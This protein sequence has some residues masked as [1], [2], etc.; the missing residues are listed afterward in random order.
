MTTAQSGPEGFYVTV[1]RAARPEPRTGFLLGPYDAREAAERNVELGRRLA[2]E[3]DPFTAF[4][5]F[6]VTRLVMQ[7][8]ARLP[9]GKL[10]HLRD[11]DGGTES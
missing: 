7:P 11:N 4:D 6:G 2:R 10:N 1:R 8:G 9:Q 5:G 3:V